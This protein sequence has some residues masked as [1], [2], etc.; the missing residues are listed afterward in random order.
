[1]KKAL[2]SIVFTM[3]TIFL[4]AQTAP[5]EMVVVE[6]GT[7]TWCQYCPGAAMGVDDL[8]ANGKKV[9]VVENHNGDSYAN[10][11]SNARNT[12]YGISGFPTATFDGNQAVVGGNHTSSMYSSYLPKYNAAIAICRNDHDRNT[13]RP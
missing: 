9:A 12:L 1:M 7:G 5:R 8:L 11:Y 3:A 13:Y 10:N 4:M 6:V 2:L